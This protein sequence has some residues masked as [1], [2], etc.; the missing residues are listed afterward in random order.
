MQRSY[1]ELLAKILTVSKTKN[2][3]FRPI[4]IFS[5]FSARTPEMLGNPA[6]Y[7]RSTPIGSPA[8]GQSPGV[9]CR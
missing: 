1:A 9:S 7:R 6:I 8:E 5:A 2:K 4:F 3:F